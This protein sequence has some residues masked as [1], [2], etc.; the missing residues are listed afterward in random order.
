MPK[1]TTLPPLERS[2]AM[3]TKK[4]DKK[5]DV[6][7]KIHDTPENIARAVLQSPP[8]PKKTLLQQQG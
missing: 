8:K 3:A 4:R 6:V 1:P 5:K 7:F 2:H